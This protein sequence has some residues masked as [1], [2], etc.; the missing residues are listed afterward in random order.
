[1]SYI[2][3]LINTC[4]FILIGAGVV[5]NL[6]IVLVFWR[7]QFK[8]ASYKLFL[9]ILAASDIL[10]IITL[11]PY[12]IK[13]NGVEIIF[14]S[15]YTCKIFDFIS[16]AFPANSSW[17]L[18]L[19]SI[20]RLISI[21]FTSIRFLKVNL[22]AKISICVMIFVWN[23]AIY[24]IRLLYTSTSSNENEIFMISN[25]SNVNETEFT[26]GF[27]N[28]YLL[29]TMVWVDLVNSTL[30]PFAIMIFCSILIIREIFLSRFKAEDGKSKMSKKD[31]RKHKKDI[32]FSATILSLNVVFFLLNLPVCIINFFFQLDNSNPIYLSV[33]LVFYSQY[34]IHFLIYLILNTD[35][36]MEFFRIICCIHS[37]KN[38]LEQS[39]LSKKKV[40]EIKY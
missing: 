5:S 25:T 35:F 38:K 7:R 39:S 3:F 17:L 12:H 33:V 22:F 31:L 29:N 11:L 6:I 15:N 13:I 21:K 19:I 14:I 36:K 28:L 1:M 9:S 32:Q 27:S 37:K 16:Y 26:C 8:K 30:I 4:P 18:A 40:T 20:E 23:L 2:D 10:S 24:M 34:T